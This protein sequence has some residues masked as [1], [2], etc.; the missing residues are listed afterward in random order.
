MSVRQFDTNIL[1]GYL[2]G[3]SEAIAA[4]DA[5]DYAV[6]SKIVQMEIMVGCKYD[7]S[8][9]KDANNH[10]DP[11]HPNFAKALTAAEAKTCAW[12]AATFSVLSIDDATA[13]FSVLVR[14]QTSKHLADTVI[15][16]TAIMAGHPIVTR[17]VSDFPP[18]ASP[19]AGYGNVAVINPYGAGIRP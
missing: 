18:L 19:P 11:A 14:K 16:A 8:V 12:M 13:D 6:I 2:S 1:I 9:P 10:P 5:C 7:S 15:H 4:V 17:N 3:H